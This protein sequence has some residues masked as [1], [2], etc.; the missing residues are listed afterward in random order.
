MAAG[1]AFADI[2]DEMVGAA[3]ESGRRSDRPR[4][5]VFVPPHPLLFATPYRPFRASPYRG[6]S[7][8]A[9]STSTRP[10]A[11]RRATEPLRPSRTLTSRQRQALDAFVMLGARLTADSTTTELRSAFRLLVLAYHPDRHPAGSDA[12]KARLTRLVADLNEH[13]QQL[14][15]AFRSAA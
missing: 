6:V 1:A 8:D 11:S 12:E 14:I 15:A 9:G 13:H 10:P 3:A 5:P 7:T 2:L 4:P